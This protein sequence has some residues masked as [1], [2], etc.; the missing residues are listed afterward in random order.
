MM[1]VFFLLACA[2]PGGGSGADPSQAF[3][4]PL[5][6]TL[7]FADLQAIGTHN[8]Y[9]VETEGVTTPEWAYTH[10][11][12]DEQLG[13]QGVRQFELDLY[14]D[15][16]EG[17]LAH[18]IPILDQTSN[19]PT[20]VECLE[21][22][23]RWSDAN[24]AHHPL[25]TLIELKDPF[26]EDPEEAVE[27]LAALEA[28][29]CSVWPPSRL[30]TADDVRRDAPDLKSAVEGV[31]W[32]TLGELRGRAMFVLHAGSSWR[33]LYLGPD[34]ETDGRLLVPDGQGDI[35]A[36]WAA[37]HAVNDPVGGAAQIGELVLAGHLVR[38]RADSDSE[39]ARAGDSSRLEAALASGAHF[40][41]TDY[42]A[43]REGVDYV[44]GIPGGTP[45]NCN[46]VTAPA[47]CSA[48]AVEDPGFVGAR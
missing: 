24:P 27:R 35:D 28:A 31:G 4:Y 29:L 22:M 47:E 10:L 25:M 23:K 5:D 37:V 16:D 1:C 39:E 7:T 26:P 48:E 12:L 41:S 2:S 30:I 6:D 17:Y 33:E 9:H 14:Y 11:P 36:P 21:D 13:L 32:P 38:T 19:C 46:P 45:S 43:P 42:P 8:S 44:A 3:D 18:H 20:F 34:G 15:E 40:L